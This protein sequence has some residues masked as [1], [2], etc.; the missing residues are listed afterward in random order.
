MFKLA[1]VS[2]IHAGYSTGRR[3]TSKGVNLRK[4]D[5]YQALKVI[6]DQ[7]ID[8]EVDA[9]IIAGDTFH[10]PNPDMLTIQF[11]QTQLRRLWQAGIHVY[12]LAGNHDTN[13]IQEDIAASSILHDPWRHIYS[14]AEPYV[15]H[16]I[17]DGINLH[18][19]SHHKYS[20]QFGTMGDVAPIPGEVNIFSTHGSCIDPL[21]EAKLTTEQSPREIVIPD[22]LLK[23]RDW[24]YTL[25][26]HIHERGWIGSKDKKRDTSKTKVYYNGSIIR[27]GYSDKDVPLGK[28]WT[29][30]SI[31]EAGVFT[32]SFRNIAQRPQFDFAEIDTTN[33]TAN[34]ITERIVANLQSTQTNGVEFVAKTAPI[35]RQT[36]SNI[37]PAKRAALDLKLI[38]ANT[39]HA[40]SWS[41][42]STVFDRK[43]AETDPSDSTDKDA[44]EESMD[45]VSVYDSWK[46]SSKTLESIQD[47][48]RE[49]VAAQG[50][51]FVKMGQEASLD[52]Q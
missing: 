16:R 2:D 4:V 27:R 44:G 22:H 34:E 49:K 43:A 39:A 15:V 28:G 20:D 40:M 19:V 29:L 38:D 18:M 7:M 8:A 48:M 25:L 23:D 26:G 46:A 45:I 17:G 35:L 42:K 9:T 33:L 21:L 6:I 41:I 13:D 30:W 12:M 31:D 50:R 10:T 3:L 11:V 36:L 47:E 52:I 32:P 1:H 24:S 5:G 14:H 51:E 37:T